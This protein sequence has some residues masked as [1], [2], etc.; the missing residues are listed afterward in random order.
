M[1]SAR[2]QWRS[3]WKAVVAF[4]LLA[5]LAGCTSTATEPSP[6]SEP[7]VTLVFSH[8]AGAYQ[9]DCIDLTIENPSGLE[10]AYTTDGSVPTLDSP[11]VVGPLRIDSSDTNA[12]LITTLAEEIP[13]WRSLATDES[14]PTAT[15]I[16]AAAILPDGTLGPT[17]T[18][19]YFVDEDLPALFD[20]MMVVS[21]VVDPFDLLDYET[22][23]MAK[24]AIYDE[25]AEQNDA[26]AAQDR[27]WEVEANYTQR[28]RGWE[29]AATIELFD[30]TNELSF[31]GP[32]GVRLR[33][34]M[35][36]VYSQ[37][38][39][40]LYFRGS[41]GM[42]RLEY[43]VFGTSADGTTLSSFKSIC[44]RAGGNATEMA[45]F[46]DLLFQE[47]LSGYDVS[48]QV[49]RPA[50]VFLNGEFYGICCLCEKYSAEFVESH[51]G[52]D[53]NNVVMFEDG[54]FDEGV[55]DDVAL[56]EELMSF[57]TRDL[58]DEATWEEFCSLVDV[59]SMVDF[60]AAQIMLANTDFNEGKNFRV[61]RYRE[62]EAGVECGDCRWRWML[63]D[64][65]FSAGI[66]GYERE[67]AEAD[68]VEF[69]LQASPLFASAMRNEAF[70][71]MMRERLVD[72][73]NNA[74]EPS[75][76]C[77]LIDETW[78]WWSPYIQMSCTRFALWFEVA[79]VDVQ[80]I[81]AFFSERPKYIIE[82][83]DRHAEEIAAQTA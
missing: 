16:R 17:F 19:T 39:F 69:M 36:R 8:D 56:Y 70:R 50:I 23:I 11:R 76:T 5:L 12:A 71:E 47:L 3:V 27:G 45:K 73:A 43:P 63:Y 75:R 24:G 30:G 58:S 14:L 2:E 7:D 21:L 31:E 67:S 51:Y 66:Y 57:A 74:L 49:M 83:Y 37:K 18:N 65:E 29:R 52:I 4:V 32:C 20:G 68:T 55:E 81:R 28:G 6:T 41:Y 64:L 53:A 26:A 46:R 77:E 1:S 78:S 54:M 10:I 48:T 44:L 59:Q 40:N 13:D 25:H 15:V 34:F 72:L 35:S 38:S 80:R 61:W 42:D 79:E 62:A 22:G 33:G 82:H 9:T 60:Y